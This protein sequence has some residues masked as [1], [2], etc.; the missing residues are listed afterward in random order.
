LGARQKL[1]TAN[2]LG[3]LAVA[4]FIGGATQ[5]IVLFVVLF[6][7]LVTFGLHDGNIRMSSSR[8]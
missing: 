5:S 1:N 6:G 2:I 8:R 7:V 4:G 3:C